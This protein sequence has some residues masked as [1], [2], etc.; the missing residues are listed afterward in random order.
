MEHFYIFYSDEGFNIYERTTSNKEAAE[1][2]V[3]ELK[4]IYEFAEY[5]ENEIPKIYKWLY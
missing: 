1:Q 5:F 2:R 4:K 3:A